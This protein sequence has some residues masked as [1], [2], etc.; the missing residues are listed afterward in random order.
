M[1]WPSGQS[2]LATNV[3]QTPLNVL[4]RWK[5][6]HRM[7]FHR[8]CVGN[9]FSKFSS[10]DAMSDRDQVCISVNFQKVASHLN[11]LLLCV[12]KSFLFSSEPTCC[13]YMNFELFS[14]ELP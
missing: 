3:R 14:N 6:L 1:I 5:E 2:H 4:K 11:L 10:Y 8:H 13:C 12:L 7:M 9:E